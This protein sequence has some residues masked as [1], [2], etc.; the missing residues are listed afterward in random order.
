M[1]PTVPETAQQI[2]E[3][4][5]RLLESQ[6]QREIYPGLMSDL[7]Y[8]KDT[9]KTAIQTC[10]G[11][12]AATAQ[13]TADLRAFLEVAYVSLADYVDE[14][15]A[16]LLREY[17]RAGEALAHDRRQ[18]REKIGSP[19]WNV[20]AESGRLAGTIA[21]AIASETEQLRREFYGYAAP[22]TR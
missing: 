20:V 14:E 11:A 10:L 7:P 4:Y 3:E 17:Q 18:T 12:L 9:I 8:P 19:A 13:L 22:L 21:Q 16:Q 15:I 5:A 6:T 1:D 2:V